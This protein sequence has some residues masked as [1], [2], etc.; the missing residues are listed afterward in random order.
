MQPALDAPTGGAH[1][2]LRYLRLGIN[3]IPLA[4]GQK[5]PYRA[6]VDLW[7][8]LQRERVTEAQAV[9]WIQQGDPKMGIG[10]VCGRISDLCCLDA[11]LDDFA[12]W[13]LEHLDHPLFAGC[14]IVET[15]SGKA[16][17]WV[18]SM[19]VP[20]VHAW[21]LRPDG[22]R[23]GEVRGEG[24]YAAAP[25]SLHPSGG[26]YR[27]RW[28]SPEE[29]QYRTD[30]DEFARSVAAAYLND[31][32]GAAP[33]PPG[34]RSY[35]VL[36]LDPEQRAEA[37]SRVRQAHFSRKVSD[38]LLKPG[39]QT[40]GQGNWVG[41]PSSSEVDFAIIVAMI[42]KGWERD[43]AEWI[44][45]GSEAA[46]GCYARGDRKGSRGRAY[47]VTTWD[48]AAAEVGREKAA[49]LVATGGN[50]SVKSVK[51]LG[52]KQSSYLI[53]MEFTRPDGSLH[54]GE[55]I[56][57]GPEM[58]RETA[59][60]ERCVEACEDIPTFL[61]T[62][63][64]REFRRFTTAV[65][66]MISDT[67]ESSSYATEVGYRENM[68]LSMLHGLPPRAPTSRGELTLGWTDGEIYFLNAP[69]LIRLLQSHDHSF[70]PSEL[71]RVLH[72]AGTTR[73]YYH[74]FTD[75][76]TAE[77]IRLRPRFRPGVHEHG[78]SP[79]DAADADS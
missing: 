56:M 51:R 62:Q 61:P 53:T 70:K 21:K 37:A 40:P 12:A 47:W 71:T 65:L 25:P 6:L 44:F 13:I 38:A 72:G 57:T 74:A 11:D 60:V 48:N 9:Q 17:I 41:C 22:V 36:S 5:E 15:G 68:V 45:A 32:P 1:P 46:D 42:R 29:M 52:R 7:K 50:F 35:R 27:T 16:H 43:E 34:D 23:C 33:T 75:G 31:N 14:W 73:V 10:L 19:D 54:Q 28:G 69:A 39:E 49:S 8:P 58:T 76:E 4:V 79:L 24:S 66:R 18:R 55:V 3:P 78:A 26:T 63:V 64:G 30:I 67:E 20:Q 2:L 59:W 77:V